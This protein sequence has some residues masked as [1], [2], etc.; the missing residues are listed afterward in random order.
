MNDYS[1]FILRTDDES[2]YVDT[3]TTPTEMDAVKS[4]IRNTTGG[5]FEYV[6]WVKDF[7]CYKLSSNCVLL[8]INDWCTQEQK[9]HMISLVLDKVLNTDATLIYNCDCGSESIYGKSSAHSHWCSTRK[10]K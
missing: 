3:I 1:L 9:I 2:A 8:A 4:F 7:N 10:N 5:P 6:K